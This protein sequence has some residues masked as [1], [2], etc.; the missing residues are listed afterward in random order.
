LLVKEAVANAL[1]HGRASRVEV[2]VHTDEEGLRLLVTDDGVGFSPDGDGGL[3]LLGMQER[4]ARL[5]GTI[6]IAAAPAG[7]T[8]VR[9]FLPPAALGGR[10]S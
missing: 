8:E 1:R 6:E 2:K 10:A 5:G 7:G 9:L 3:G 4:A